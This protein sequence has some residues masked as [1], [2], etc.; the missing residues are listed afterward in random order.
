MK[1][2]ICGLSR[3][4]DIEIVNKY[5]PDYIGFVFASSPRQVSFNKAKQLRRLVNNKIQ[6]V[7]VFVDED[8]DKILSLV[9][10]YVIDVIQLHGNETND[11]IKYLKQ[12]TNVPIIK[13]IKVIDE[14]SLDVKYDVDY[15]LLD[16]KVSGSGQSFDWSLLKQLDKP[17]FLA[18]GI[19]LDN[20]SEALSFN[21][22][23]LDISSGVE[24]NG[25]KDEA[26]IKEII[27]RIRND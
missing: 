9:N 13:A 8:N 27:R 18:G 2:K 24:T 21:Q 23:G 15:Y 26:K 20:I 6:V 5:L 25:I 4:E 11:D 17:Y 3:G 16:N 12:Y 1:I 14:S 19:N 10:D 22:Y 7:G